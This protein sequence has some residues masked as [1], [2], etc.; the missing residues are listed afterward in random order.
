MG[1]PCTLQTGA[2]SKEVLMFHSEFLLLISVGSRFRRWAFLVF[3]NFIA[4][5]FVKMCSS[6]YR[7]FIPRYDSSVLLHR[8]AFCK[9]SNVNKYK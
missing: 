2:Q 3:H 6:P 9:A 4:T 8:L 5:E 7:R 1:E